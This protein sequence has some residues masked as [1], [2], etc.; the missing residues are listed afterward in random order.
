MLAELRVL[1]KIDTNAIARYCD[2]FVQWQAAAKYLNTKGLT[3]IVRCGKGETRVV[4][5]P[6]TVLYERFSRILN[7]L[8][9]SFGLTP[10]A[11]TRISTQQERKQESDASK[12]L[13]L[14]PNR[15]G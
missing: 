14:L 15:T 2:A 8:E 10:S 9:Q 1:A 4:A 13:K 6:Q 3:A 11:R 12:L 5:V 7:Q